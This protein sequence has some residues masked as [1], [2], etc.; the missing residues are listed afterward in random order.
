[1]LNETKYDALYALG[2]IEVPS[3]K[4]DFWGWVKRT[5]T[6]S[7][8]SEIEYYLSDCKDHA[9][10]NRKMDLLIHRGMI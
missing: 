2:G 9:D 5:F 10:L 7:Y 1:M 4:T 8:Q 6:P 3:I